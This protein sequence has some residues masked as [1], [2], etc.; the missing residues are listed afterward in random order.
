[1]ALYLN[2]PAEEE[3]EAKK[4]GALWNPDAKRW[5][6]DNADF[7]PR[8]RKWILGPDHDEGLVVCDHIYILEGECSCSQC[9]KTI[10]VIG[11]GIDDFDDIMRFNEKKTGYSRFKDKFVMC[12]SLAPMPQDIAAYVEKVYNYKQAYS[13]ATQ[14][15]E[16]CNCCKHCGSIQ[17][18]RFLL[19]EPDSPLLPQSEEEAKALTLYKVSL[20]EDIV[21]YNGYGEGTCEDL[22][23]MY[24]PRKD[25]VID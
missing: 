25:L 3:D 22:I 21:L 5:Y 12:S 8:F 24:T 4:N 16:Y 20:K 10:K 18:N 9:G 6:A 7:Y 23:Q 13:K 2:V 11:F 19:N 17:R 14:S 1:M 15:T